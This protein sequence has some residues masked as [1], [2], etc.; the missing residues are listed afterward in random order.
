M[1]KLIFLLIVLNISLVSAADVA[2]I[3]KNPNFPNSKF[4]DSFQELN[5]TVDLINVR[6]IN[7]VNLSKYRLLFVGDERFSRPN[8][9]KIY[10]FNSLI[11][12]T[13]H[14]HT[15]GL[16]HDD[17][18][19]LAGNSPLQVEKNNEIITVYD[20]CCF[21]SGNGLAIPYYY[22]LY[23]NKNENMKSITSTLLNKEDSVI[24]FIN[25][26][27]ALANGKI[28][29]G[30]IVFFGITETRYWTEDA[31]NLFKLS[32]NLAI[33]SKDNDNDGFPENEDCN[34]KDSNIHPGAAEIPN[35]GI[36]ENCDGYDLIIIPPLE[37][38]EPNE[39]VPVLTPRQTELEILLIRNKDNYI[40]Q[41]KKITLSANNNFFDPENF[42][43][44]LD[45]NPNLEEGFYDI[46]ILGRTNHNECRLNNE[47][48]VRMTIFVGAEK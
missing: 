18:S 47:E 30:K 45:L 19:Q 21:S 23:L 33:S 8:D 15:W 38:E 41:S 42:R 31:K 35:N 29:K 39:T 12:N 5:L 27:K 48:S 46:L 9:I 14:V 13:F 24:G 37:Q 32:V 7:A 34:D 22:L 6:N 26:S 36:D 17:I 40:V 3:L 16:S 25:G 11:A 20:R 43:T 10:N 44:T 2:Y 1:K 28:S 4:I